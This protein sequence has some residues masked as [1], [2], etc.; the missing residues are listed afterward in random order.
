L[1]T[2]H[3]V[4]LQLSHFFPVNSPNS[5]VRI[6]STR[7]RNTY[8]GKNKASKNMCPLAE[9]EDHE[10]ANINRCMKVLVTTTAV[11]LVAYAPP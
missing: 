11:V 6:N 2:V 5:G 9:L 7:R 8:L 1:F 10:F 3:I 4:L